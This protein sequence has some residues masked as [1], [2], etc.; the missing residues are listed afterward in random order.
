MEIPYKKT[1]QD[2]MIFSRFLRPRH[3]RSGTNMVRLFLGK[4]RRKPQVFWGYIMVC[5]VFS[6]YTNPIIQWKESNIYIYIH[7]VYNLI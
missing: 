4:M 7:T 6:P 2:G 1:A 3:A 5:C